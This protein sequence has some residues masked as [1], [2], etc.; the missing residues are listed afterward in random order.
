MTAFAADDIATAIARGEL[1]VWYQP[2]VDAAT[3]RVAA[4]EALARWSHPTQGL[5]TPASFL[6]CESEV[7][8]MVSSFVLGRA[9]AQARNWG[10]VMIAVNLPP[11][12]FGHDALVDRLDE[13]TAAAGLPAQRLE[14]EVLE[15]EPFE[16]I[17][18]AR[19][20][21][22]RIRARGMRIALDDFGQGYSVDALIAGLP[23]NKIKLARELVTSSRAA[24][25]V[26]EVVR[27]AHAL[28]IEVTAEGVETEED[29]KAMREAGCDYLQGYLFARPV[30]AEDIPALIAARL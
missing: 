1:D 17:A 11:H 26:P 25:I 16:N 2:Q 24:Q 7:S 9:C 8:L 29:A 23:V 20:A 10:D 19:E 22:R 6:G 3:M 12:A 18:A 5:L 4:V 30:P 27:L 13:A 28:N 21:M 14:I 15:T